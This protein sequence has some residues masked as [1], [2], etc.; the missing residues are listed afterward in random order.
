MT[1][2]G[3]GKPL[4][5]DYLD[6]FCPRCLAH[7]HEQLAERLLIRQWGWAYGPSL[8]WL[9]HSR[10]WPRGNQLRKRYPFAPTSLPS[11]KISVTR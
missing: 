1:C 9:V 2:T 8:Q 6:D 3:C 5:M 11:R 10:R 4:M 7:V